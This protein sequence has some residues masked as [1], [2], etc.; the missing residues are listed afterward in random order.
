LT[1]TPQAITELIHSGLPQASEL[2]FVVE[3]VDQEGRVWCRQPYREIMLRPGGT[4]SGPTMMGLAD[5]AMYAAVLHRLGRVEMAVTQNLNINFLHRPAPRDLL[6][7]VEIIKM[8]KRSVVLEVRLYSD[9][10]PEMVAHGTGTY[11]LPPSHHKP[12]T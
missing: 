10:S 1:L 9:G 11:A 6:A 7:S 12:E 3:R 2:G 8:G 4:L 5:A